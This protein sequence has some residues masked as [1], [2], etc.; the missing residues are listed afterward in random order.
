MLNTTFNF[1]TSDAAEHG[2]THDDLTLLLQL[3]LP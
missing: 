3:A 2:W 1:P